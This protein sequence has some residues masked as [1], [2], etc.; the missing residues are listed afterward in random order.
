MEPVRVRSAIKNPMLR[1]LVTRVLLEY[2]KTGSASQN[3]N[4]KHVRRMSR[5][6]R[7]DG[8]SLLRIGIDPEILEAA[9]V[10]SDLGKEPHIMSRYITEYDGNYFRAFLDHSRISMREGNQIRV[11]LG[12]DN[13]TWRKI[14]SSIVGHDGPSIPGSWWKTNYEREL[15]KR[16]P[17]I[18]SRDAL[19]H[20]YLDRIDQGGLFRSRSGQ[21]NGGLRKISYDIFTKAG[22]FKGNLAGVIGE[23]FGN[24]RI[25]TQDQIDYLDEVVKPKLLGSEQLPKIVR[26]MKRKYIESEKYFERIVVDENVLDRV[27]VVLDTGENI[28]VQSLDEFWKVLAK[29]TPKGM[30]SSFARRTHTA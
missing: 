14:L 3:E 27:R 20:A 1:K 25:G 21:L 2:R 17:G 11:E 18:H 9:I 22:P 8:E 23:I 6:V 30:I 12:I 28:E 4:L 15:G 26:E 29:V 19:I 7:C 5:E 24:T 13:R 16:Y 10:L